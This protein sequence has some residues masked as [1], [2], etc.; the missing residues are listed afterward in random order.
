MPGFGSEWDAL[1]K[2][3]DFYA[4]DFLQTRWFGF[5]NP[6]GVKTLYLV[7][8]SRDRAWVQPTLLY[9]YWGSF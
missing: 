8:T 2:G 3:G 9:G 7:H 6:V 1:Y 5:R 4:A